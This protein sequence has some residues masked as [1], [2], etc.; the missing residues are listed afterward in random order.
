MLMIINRVFPQSLKNIWHATQ[1][2]LAN[3]IFGFPSRRLFL[4]G[5]TGTDGKTTT[6][7]HMYRMLYQDKVKV[8]LITSVAAYIGNDTIDT[9]FHVTTPNSWHLQRLLRRMVRQGVTHVV[10]EATSHA[11]DQHRLLGCHFP[12]A[13]YTN[14]TREHLDYH[15]TF[16]R[17]LKTKSKLARKASLIILNADDPS[18]RELRRMVPSHARVHTYSLKLNSMWLHLIRQHFK[19]TYNQSNALA[20][21]TCAQNLKVSKNA[22]KT[23]LTSFSG[24]PG[25]LEYLPN[26]RGLTVVVD[27][28][29]TPNALKSVLTSLKN[30]TKGKLIAV[31]GAAGLRDAK[32]RPLMGEIGAQLADEVILTAEDPRTEDVRFIIKSMLEGIKTNHGHVHTIIDRKEAIHFA[33]NR[34]A[35][36]GDTVVLLGKGHEKSMNLDGRHETAWSDQETAKHALLQL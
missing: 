7:T 22:I 24:I 21:V 29:H 31:Y 13:V 8:A 14:I 23:A 35:K 27:F 11:L 32:K 20:A 12:V 1:A 2:V 25:R 36:A 18:Y 6:S 17:Y 33:I 26:H 16:K 4:I 10:I 9:G 5:V 3:A 28:A 19:E 15:K 34:L 30:T